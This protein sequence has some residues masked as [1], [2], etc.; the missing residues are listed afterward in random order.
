MWAG[1]LDAVG[2]GV[3]AGVLGGARASVQDSVQDGVRDAVWDGVRDA[4]RAAVRD[5]VWDGVR[6][7]VG[8][9]VWDGVRDAVW[10][11]VWAG[12]WDAVW[13]AVGAGVLGGVWDGVQAGVQDGVGDAVRDAVWDAVWDSVRAGVWDAVQD[14]VRDGVQDWAQEMMFGGHD[15][16]WLGFADWFG[17]H[18]MSQVVAP[19]DG[20]T[21]VAMSAGWWWAHT[22]IAIV[23]DRPEVLNDELWDPPYGRRLH[24]ETGPSV[25]YRDG[26]ELHHWHGLL[27]PAWVIN[28]T[29]A[30][31]DILAEPN[32]EIRRAAIESVGWDQFLA[33][34]GVEP[35]SVEDDPANTGCQ[36]ALYRLPQGVDA[37]LDDGDQL[38]VCQNG[39]VER[40]GRRR[41]FGLT[42]PAEITSAV[43]AAAATYDLD[44]ATYR[45]LRV[46]T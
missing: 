37:G 10:A 14:A 17:H 27:V 22:N 20:L 2:A 32:I 19:L 29:K 21:R 43:A 7:G 3:W 35:I 44:E 30:V 40:D 31:G 33:G 41:T 11:G 26:W 42:V 36:L 24:C 15:A 18:G 1:V 45:R 5:G 9:A 8:G 39:T 38:L 46:R 23:S 6:A 25:R 28:R 16:A 4:V 34:L 12:V 13:A